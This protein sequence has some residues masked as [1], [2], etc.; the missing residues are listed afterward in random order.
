MAW[1]KDEKVRERKLLGAPLRALHACA[2]APVF[3]TFMLPDD[4]H[5]SRPPLPAKQA[6]RYAGHDDEGDADRSA[7][8]PTSSPLL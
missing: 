7:P 1:M 4:V 6:T 8:P 2:V 3:P 5:G